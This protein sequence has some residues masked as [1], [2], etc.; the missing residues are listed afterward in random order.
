M[1]R[2]LR[3]LRLMCW[4]SA[5]KVQRMNWLSMPLALCRMFVLPVPSRVKPLFNRRYPITRSLWI[6]CRQTWWARVNGSSLGG[7]KKQK[8]KKFASTILG[9]CSHARQ[10]DT[11]SC[12]LISDMSWINYDNLC[13]W[14]SSH[15]IRS[16]GNFSQ[17]VSRTIWTNMYI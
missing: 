10:R 1:Y 3:V 7:S 15:W 2:S 6:S 16:T 14:N 9:A 12:L 13:G 11:L 4:A 8:S 17:P 5:F